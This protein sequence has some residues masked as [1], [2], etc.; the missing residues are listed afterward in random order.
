[1]SSISK[2]H[3]F[4]AHQSNDIYFNLLSC[5]CV[6]FSSLQFHAQKQRLRILPKAKSFGRLVFGV[7]GCTSIE[8]RLRR[9]C[10]AQACSGLQVEVCCSV[11]IPV[12][13][14]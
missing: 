11:M 5:T 7:S 9:G 1:M 3:L 12:F 4:C 13:P 8:D 10:S 6:T 2:D 14:H